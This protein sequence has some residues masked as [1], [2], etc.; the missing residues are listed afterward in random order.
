MAK[1]VEKQVFVSETGQKIVVALLDND[2]VRVRYEGGRRTAVTWH[3]TGNGTNSTTIIT[4]EE[5][6]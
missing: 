4:P 3:A 5:R 6:A 1:Q 2:G